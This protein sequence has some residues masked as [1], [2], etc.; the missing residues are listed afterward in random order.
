MKVLTTEEMTL[1]IRK[2]FR[3]GEDWGVTYSGWFVPTPEQHTDQI[4]KT[5]SVLLTD[6]GEPTQPIKGEM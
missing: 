2:A 1:L 6:L 4:D 5:V 3:A